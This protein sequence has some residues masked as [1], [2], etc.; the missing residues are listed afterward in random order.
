M[1]GSARRVCLPRLLH[2]HSLPPGFNGSSEHVAVRGKEK[3]FIALWTELA[4]WGTYCTLY[5]PEIQPYAVTVNRGDWS[6][7]SSHGGP[8]GAFSW[9]TDGSGP[10]RLTLILWVHLFSELCNMAE[11]QHLCNIRG[12]SWLKGRQFNQSSFQPFP[13]LMENNKALSN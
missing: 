12:L 9:W 13:G 1:L 10:V 5:P 4:P 7:T 11:V 2:T 6:V 8:V 3:N